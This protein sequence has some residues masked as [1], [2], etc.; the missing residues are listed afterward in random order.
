MQWRMIGCSSYITDALYCNIT[1]IKRIDDFD[2]SIHILNYPNAESVLLCVFYVCYIDRYLL[3]QQNRWWSQIWKNSLIPQF[4]LLEISETRL[5]GG[6][7]KSV[8]QS[9]TDVRRI[10]PW[11][12]WILKLHA[13]RHW[14]MTDGS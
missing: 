4:P 11:R 3:G 13:E 1:R 5:C 7:L 2:L 6:I 9:I 8:F 12:M 14:W 10:A